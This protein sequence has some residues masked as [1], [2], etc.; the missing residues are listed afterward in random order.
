MWD[1]RYDTE[2]YVYGTAPN[3]FL[4]E[5]VHRLP[6]GRILCL[7]EGEGRNAVFLAGLGYRVTAV[8]ASAVGL[9]KAR[10]LAHE[11]GLQIE[12]Q[13]ADLATYPIA[14]QAWDGIVSIFCHLPAAVR[15][16]LHQRV[17]AGLRPGGV[18]ILEA[19]RPAQLAFG[20]GGPKE[21][22]M[23]MSLEDLEQELHP[24]TFLHARELEREVIEGKFHTGTGAVVQL[25][26]RKD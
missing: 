5:W 4:A 10:R 24:L 9:A 18:L 15:R 13:V 3:R 11:K 22:S 14:E 19:Y 16:D 6:P 17:K 23:M 1:E 8:D 12:T 26:G 2:E 21:A 7:A 20:T 25:V